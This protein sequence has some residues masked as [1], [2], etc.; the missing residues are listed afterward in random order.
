MVAADRLSTVT[1]VPNIPLVVFAS[2]SRSLVD[3]C[4]GAR[5][6]GR[7]V[8]G[9]ATLNALWVTETMCSAIEKLLVTLYCGQKVP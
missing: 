3:L 4:H 9:A 8:G 2:G 5:N 7:N 6:G 1:D